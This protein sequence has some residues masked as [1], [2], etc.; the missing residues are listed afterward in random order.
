MTEKSNDVPDLA[1][2]LALLHAP[3]VGPV[4]F[5]ALLND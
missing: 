3:G 5:L 1:Y 4:T 2:W